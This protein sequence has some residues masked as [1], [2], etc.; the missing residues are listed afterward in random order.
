MP[1]AAVTLWVAVMLASARASQG[2]PASHPDIMLRRDMPAGLSTARV[3]GA[4]VGMATATGAGTA[5]TGGAG[6]ATA[7]GGAETVSASG[8]PGGDGTGAGRGIRGT[9]DT[10][11]DMTR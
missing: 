3:R 6:A 2:T 5:T 10:D 4:T 9:T 7:G 11:L 8:V 1:W